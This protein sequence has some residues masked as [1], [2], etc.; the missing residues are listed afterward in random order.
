MYFDTENI[1]LILWRGRWARLRTYEFYLQEVAAQ[2]F[3]HSLSQQSQLLVE[4]L[5]TP[6]PRV[7]R[8]FLHEVC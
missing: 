6:C 3:T 8:Y 2:V 4:R 5:H 1:P 7:F